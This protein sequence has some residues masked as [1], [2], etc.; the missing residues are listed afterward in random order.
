MIGNF[1]L[2]LTIWFLL[3]A[4]LN[5]ANIMIGISIALI[6]PYGSNS[7]RSGQAGELLQGSWKVI[8]A[9]IQAYWEAFELILRPHQ[10]EEIVLTRVKTRR[11][12][13]LMFLDIFLIT[14]T[15]KTIVLKYDPNGYYEVHQVKRV[16]KP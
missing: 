10:A 3:T 8:A 15:P 7:R 5:P 4:S 12:P 11:S 13:K 9:S 6:L 2:R 16:Q 14:L 1:I